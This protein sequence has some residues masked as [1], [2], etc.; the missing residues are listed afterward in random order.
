[1][2]SKRTVKI[3]DGKGKIHL[4]TGHE[5]PDGVHT[6]GFVLSLTSALDAVEWST[7]R[8]GRFNLGNAQYSLYGRTGGPQSRSGRV[9]KK[10]VWADNIKQDLET[11]QIMNCV[12]RPDGRYS[13]RA[14][15]ASF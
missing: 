14:H 6:Y 8:L 15:M 11:L 5:D 10:F 4:T 13:W 7:P 1:M 2:V 9:Q 12:G 3:M